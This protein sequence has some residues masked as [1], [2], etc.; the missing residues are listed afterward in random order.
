MKSAR[1]LNPQPHI[2]IIEEITRAKVAAVF[3][4]VFQLLD[5]DE[6]G[7]KK[8]YEKMSYKQYLN[9]TGNEKYK[10]AFDRFSEFAFIRFA[11][12]DYY[13]CRYAKRV[14]NF[15]GKAWELYIIR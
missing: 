6:D 11:E 7:V 3:G 8:G 5:R 14:V 10:N 12:N 15:G 1:S 9:L 4:D 13:T 2:L